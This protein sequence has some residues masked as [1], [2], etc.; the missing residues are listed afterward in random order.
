MARTCGLAPP[1]SQ[2]GPSTEGAP[3]SRLLPNQLRV[4]LPPLW[5][6]ET[7]LVPPGI[8]RSVPVG[9][10]LGALAGS[11]W[12]FQRVH[13]SCT[14]E[15]NLK[16]GGTLTQH[17]WTFAASAWSS[18]TAASWRYPNASTIPT[19]PPVCSAWPC[20]AAATTGRMAREPLTV[21]HADSVLPTG[22]LKSRNGR[23]V[24]PPRKS[25][26]Q[27]TS[28][29]F[30]SASVKPTARTNSGHRIGRAP[31]SSSSCRI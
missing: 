7:S 22:T 10:T 12:Y 19:S 18:T 25:C 8:D 17:D 3:W 14:W 27:R 23:T 13:G 16:A 2:Y 15:G 30:R 1:M 5:A 28:A 4:T 31:R 6:M 29:G 20:A 11:N 24:A 21:E 26:F 9:S